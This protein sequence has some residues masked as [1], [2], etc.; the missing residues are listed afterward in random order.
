MFKRSAPVN[1]VSS[2]NDSE[3]ADEYDGWFLLVWPKASRLG[4]DRTIALLRANVDGDVNDDLGYGSLHCIFEAAFRFFYPQPQHDDGREPT[5]VTS[6]MASLLYDHGDLHLIETFLDVHDQWAD[7]ETMANWILAVLRRFGAPL[8]SLATAND[9]LAQTIVCDCIPLWWPRLLDHLAKTHYS[10]KKALHLVFDVETYMLEHPMDVA[11]SKYLTQHLPDGVVRIVA[12]YLAPPLASL[13][14]ALRCKMPLAGYLPSVVWPRRDALSSMR[15][16]SCIAL[17]TEYLC[18]PGE[19]RHFSTGHLP[20]LV[21]LALLTVGT[22]AFGK[23]DAEVQIWRHHCTFRAACA[24]I[25]KK[26]LFSTM[27]AVVMEEYYVSSWTR[28]FHKG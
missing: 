11:T 15:L 4:Y 9:V 18:S 25:T 24:R 16:A 8:V 1:A 21:Y 2:S 6:K 7:D 26:M 20:S 12:T 23:V 19:H 13:L 28:H 27:Q 22:P 3:L 14:D 5:Q 17:A 10:E